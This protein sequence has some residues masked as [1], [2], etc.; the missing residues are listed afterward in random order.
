[1]K[2]T[3]KEKENGQ[4]SNR[5]YTRMEQVFVDLMK[6]GKPHTYGEF[7]EIVKPSGISA[8]K[9]HIVAIRK[10]VPAGE[11]II[12]RFMNRRLVYQWVRLLPSANDG[13]S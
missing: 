13:R 7:L 8:V 5:G 3:I 12:C 6:D 2:G 1:M 9:R 10:K 11:A 4:V